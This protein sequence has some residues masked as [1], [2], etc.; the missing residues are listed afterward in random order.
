MVMLNSHLIIHQKKAEHKIFYPPQRKTEKEYQKEEDEEIDSS[1]GDSDE[2]YTPGKQ[3][4][5]SE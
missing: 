1:N 5:E 3:T 4:S 2:S